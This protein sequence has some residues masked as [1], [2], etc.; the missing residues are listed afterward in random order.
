MNGIET[1]DYLNKEVKPYISSSTDHIL[2][3]M[4]IRWMLRAPIGTSHELVLRF[5]DGKMKKSTSYM[6]LQ[7]NF[8]EFQESEDIS[9]VSCS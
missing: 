8:Q 1:Q 3:D 6:K 2:D 9:Q 4:A 5:P 7:P